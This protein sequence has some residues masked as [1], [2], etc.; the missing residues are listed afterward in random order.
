[1]LNA[2]SAVSKRSVSKQPMTGAVGIRSRSAR[3][4]AGGTDSGP[5]FAVRGR[6]HAIEAIRVIGLLATIVRRLGPPVCE[7]GDTRQEMDAPSQGI[8]ILRAR[9]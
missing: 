1:M 5:S 9:V 4:R 7:G 8:R 6:V 3:R 2:L